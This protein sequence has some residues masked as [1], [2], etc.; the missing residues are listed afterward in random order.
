MFIGS[1]IGIEEDYIVELTL[2]RKRAE[3]GGFEELWNHT[4]GEFFDVVNHEGLSF[5]KPGNA[6]VLLCLVLFFDIFHQV[7]HLKESIVRFFLVFV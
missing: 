6:E 2:S 7:H 5:G 3:F 4:A 1:G